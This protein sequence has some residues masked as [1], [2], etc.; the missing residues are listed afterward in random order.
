[1]TRVNALLMRGK[2]FR[3]ALRAKPLIVYLAFST[4]VCYNDVLVCT[5]LRPHPIGSAVILRYCC[6]VNVAV[7]RDHDQIWARDQIEIVFGVA[8]AS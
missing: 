8:A 1:M 3:V 2:G 7:A 5:R 6:T 4:C